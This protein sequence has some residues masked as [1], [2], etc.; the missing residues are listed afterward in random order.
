MLFGLFLLAATPA[1]SQTYYVYSLRETVKLIDGKKSS[2]VRL[3]QKLL[4]SQTLKIANSGM[5]ILFDY[6]KRKLYTINTPCT[7]RIKDLIKK[8]AS[9]LKDLSQRY[10]QYVWKQ[11]SGKG[12]LMTAT[13][14]MGRTAAS[15]RDADSTLMIVDSLQTVQPDTTVIN[16]ER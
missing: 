5:V 10:A 14:S 6:D 4:A 12:S 11:I 9:S 16:D 2:D 8:P 7:G 3:R 1:H 13:A 15:Y